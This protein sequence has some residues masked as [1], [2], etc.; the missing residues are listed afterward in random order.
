HVP[1]DAYR[2]DPTWDQASAIVRRL[3][4]RARELGRSFGV[5]L[6]NTL[7][8][9]NCSNFLPRSERLAYLSGAPLHVLAMHLVQRFRHTFGPALP[10]S[11]SAGIDR[12]NYPDAVRLGL[13]PVTVCTDLLKQGGYGRLQAYATAL[14]QRMDASNAKT[15]GEFV[16][17]TAIDA[18]V[19]SLENNPRYRSD[20]AHAPRKTGHPM[21]AYDCS[22]CDLCI[23]VCPNAAIFL[24]PPHRV[25]IFDDWCNDCGNCETFCPDLGAP[26]R[27]KPRLSSDES[28][29]GDRY[30]VL[31]PAVYDSSRVNSINCL[32]L[33]ER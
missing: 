26:N 28:A 20:H 1:N 24:M 17:W 23:G 5:K 21:G 16:D 27:V 33:E 11:F 10:I 4:A 32:S 14:A 29:W 12:F 2:K 18:Y 9:D 8:V 6:T 3:Q 7:V 22:E 15:L 19:A 31:R 13:A 25:A 30:A